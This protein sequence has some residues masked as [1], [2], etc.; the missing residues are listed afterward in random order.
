MRNNASFVR[1]FPAFESFSLVCDV[2]IVYTIIYIRTKTTHTHTI[3]LY[4]I[5]KS[6]F[7]RLRLHTRSTN[8]YDINKEKEDPRHN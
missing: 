3:C 2:Y 7:S 1:I 5:V 8:E 4:G 6:F